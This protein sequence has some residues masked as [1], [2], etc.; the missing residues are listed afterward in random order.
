M[1]RRPRPALAAPRAR[2]HAGMQRLVRDLNRVLQACPALHELDASPDGFGWIDHADAAHSI[3]VFERRARSGERVL[4]LCNFTRWCAT[5]GASACPRPAPGRSS[6]TPTP[7]CMAA[8]TSSTGRWPAS[9]CP[10]RPGPV[11]AAQPAAPRH[12]D[13]GAPWLTPPTPR[14][15][16][17][18]PGPGR[19]PHRHG[20]AS[21]LPW[22][23]DATA[24]EL[25]LFDDDG[26]RAGRLPPRLQRGCVA[27][28]PGGRAGHRVWPARPR[29]VGAQ[30]GH[31]FNLA[32][33]LLD[34]GPTGR[35]PLRPP[36][37]RPRRRSA[38]LV[39]AE[40][41]CTSA[42]ARPDDPT[43]PGPATTPPPP[44]RPRAGPRASPHAP[45]GP[46]VVAELTVLL[47]SPRARPHDGPPGIPPELRGSYAAL[48]HPAMIAHYKAWASPPVAAAAAFPGRRGRLQLRGLANH[49]GYSP[50][51]WLA[52]SPAT[53]AA[54]PA[55]RQAA[56]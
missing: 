40:L 20:R 46:R 35:R 32:K 45:A 28:L 53:P 17:A 11:G 6:S 24:V 14:S 16:P 49:W 22:A 4:V 34:P 48:A 30:Q 2:P 19:E 27:W 37:P 25:C 33:L 5:A 36:G 26:C 38:A 10:G 43:R 21:T 1:E 54:G 55:P 18:G 23:P 9:P 8:P 7:T 50:I 3:L 39:A 13:A 31:R 42:A 41:P 51:A 15:R 52:P 47:R 12:P 44:S 56:S 29:P